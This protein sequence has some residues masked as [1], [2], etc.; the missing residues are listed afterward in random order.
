MGQWAGEWMGRSWW[1][2]WE[3]G[4]D[5]L[6]AVRACRLRR[7]LWRRSWLVSWERRLS[8]TGGC[9]VA[10]LSCPELPITVARRGRSRCQALE[11]ARTALNRLLATRD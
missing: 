6:D 1:R 10:R 9:W 8:P 4:L 5:G 3:A 11:R 7:R 2:I